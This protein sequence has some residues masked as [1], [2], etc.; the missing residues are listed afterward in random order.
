MVHDGQALPR[1]PD[2]RFPPTSPPKTTVKIACRFEKSTSR[3]PARVSQIATQVPP[4]SAIHCDSKILSVY[5]KRRTSPPHHAPSR[6]R[7][8]TPQ[9]AAP[10][11]ARSPV[12]LGGRNAPPYFRICTQIPAMSRGRRMR[13]C[14]GRGRWMG[15]SGKAKRGK[16]L[17]ESEGYIQGRI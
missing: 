7:P 16:L 11:A 8:R 10:E 4:N 14:A 12:R 6:Q 15:W 3:H 1:K 5:T 9:Q 13:N 17:S 2:K